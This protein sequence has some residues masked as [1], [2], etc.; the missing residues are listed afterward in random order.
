M[1]LALEKSLAPPVFAR[2]CRL[3]VPFPPPKE[4]GFPVKV[5]ALGLQPSGK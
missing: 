5:F 3:A 1:D 4:G 2:L